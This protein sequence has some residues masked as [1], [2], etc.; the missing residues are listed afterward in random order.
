VRE[1]AGARADVGNTH[2]RLQCADP[3]QLLA[4]GP[5]AVLSS[6][7]HVVLPSEPLIHLG[8]AHSVLGNFVLHVRR[9]GTVCPYTPDDPKTNGHHHDDQRAVW[10]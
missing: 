10:K 8:S 1:L 3:S 9:H 6:A 7:Q 4:D 2:A 5:M